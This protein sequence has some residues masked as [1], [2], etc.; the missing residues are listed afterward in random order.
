VIVCGRMLTFYRP[1]D[2][3]GELGLLLTCDP[4]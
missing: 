2:C 3:V 4:K 1:G